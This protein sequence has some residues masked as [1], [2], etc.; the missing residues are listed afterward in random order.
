M[1]K[2]ISHLTSGS[3][4]IAMAAIAAACDNSDAPALSAPDSDMLNIDG[5]SEKYEID[6]ST[7]K[8]SWTVLSAPEWTTIS[9]MNGQSGEKTSV[10]VENNG[11]GVDRTGDVVIQYADGSKRS[12]RINQSR[13]T[14][15]FH[16]ERSQ[17]VGWGLDVTTYMDSRA[18]TDQIFNTEKVR[19]YSSDAIT[20]QKSNR[21]DILYFQG[22]SMSTVTD[23]LS[24]ALNLSVKV[25]AFDGSLSGAF[26]KNSMKQS[27]RYFSWM[28]GIYQENVVTM[29]V[30]TDDAQD[31]GLFTYDFA[32]A[33]KNVIDSKGSDESIRN[34]ID[35]YGTHFIW[36][37]GLGGYIDYFYSFEQTEEMDEKKIQAA[38]KFGYDSKFGLKAD[39]SNSAAF[40]ATN[41]EKIEKFFVRGGD[42]ITITNLVASGEMNESTVINWQLSLRDEKKY[43]LITFNISGISTLF[44]DDAPDYIGTKIDNY[45]SRVM[46]YSDIPV[47]RTPRFS[48]Q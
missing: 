36:N 10:Y 11:R 33:R 4:V 12:V 35:R 19:A 1:K 27:N 26:D 44:P 32:A 8:T 30:D 21:Q 41:S 38:L 6:N 39:V 20:T 23:K 22:E 9:K 31:M 47:T 43:E 29:H 16:M 24:A 48:Q 14:D 45:I 3:L 46:Y 34:L 42:A 28:R 15:A 7:H 5:G 2:L 25:S 37:A 13:S 17:G 18:I 40:E